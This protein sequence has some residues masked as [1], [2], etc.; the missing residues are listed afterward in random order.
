[1]PQ[2]VYRAVLDRILARVDAISPA[3][4]IHCAWAVPWKE[5][6]IPCCC[7]TRTSRL[8]HGAGET[9]EPAVDLQRGDR[10]K[11]LLNQGLLND[12]RS[13]AEQRQFKVYYHRNID[14]LCAR[15]GSQRGGA[16]TLGPPGA[17]HDIPGHIHPAFEG[18]GLI[19]SWPFVWQSRPAG[20][21]MGLGSAS[22]CLSHVNLSRSDVSIPC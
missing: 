18:N 9:P 6:V 21:G 13:A 15:P 20:G 5:V 19:A 22:F 11:E 4:N 10:A 3:S 14:I 8:Q 16:D 17:G 12:L 7:S 2:P 1:M